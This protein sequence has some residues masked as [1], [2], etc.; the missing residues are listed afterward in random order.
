MNTVK[1][2]ERLSGRASTYYVDGK[3]TNAEGNEI[4]NPVYDANEPGKQEV[5]TAVPLKYQSNFWRGLSIPLVNC[6]MSLILIWSREQVITSIERRVITL[7][8][9]D[10]S[11]KNASFQIKDKKL[12][13]AAVTLSTGDDNKFLEQSKPGFKSTTKWKKYRSEMTN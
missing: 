4:S 9:R 1:I 12:Y 10:T 5:E 8:R 11:L 2:I 6:K 7:I 3:I 13:V